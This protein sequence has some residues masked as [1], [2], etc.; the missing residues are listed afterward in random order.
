MFCK[1]C[2][3]LLMPKEENGKKV[4]ACSC[5]YKS[6]EKPTIIEKVVGSKDIE[7][8]EEIETMPL[9]DARCDKCDHTKAYHW[10]LQTRASDE[11]ETMFYK[12]QKCKHTWREYK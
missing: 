7:I 4:L 6:T 10:S 9:V 2:G 11:P 1:V 8:M 5:G 12:C 3:S